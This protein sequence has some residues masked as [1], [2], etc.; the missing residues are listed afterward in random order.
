MWKKVNGVGCMIGIQKIKEVY[1]QAFKLSYSGYSYKELRKMFSEYNSQIIANAQFFAF[2]FRRTVLKTHNYP[3]K[4]NPKLFLRKQDYKFISKNQVEIIYK[5]RNRLKLKVFPTE[6]QLKLMKENRVKGAILT[7]EFFDL[8]IEK[9]ME[10]PRWEDCKSII[11]V[12]IGINNIAVAVAYTS[13]F[14]KPAFFKGGEWKHLCDRKRKITRSK[15]YKHLTNRQN[16]ILHTVSKKVVEYA[17]QF[18]KPI[19]VMER[20][21]NFNNNSWNKRFNFLLGNWARRKLQKMI[22]Y[23]ANWEGIP[24]FYV[25]PAFTSV[26]CHYCGKKGKRKGSIF[27]CSRCGRQY[28]ADLN[29]SMNL[30]LKFRQFLDEREQMIGERSGKGVSPLSEGKTYLP[31]QAQVRPGNGNQMKRMIVT[32]T[33]RFAYGIGR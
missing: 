20:L 22:E 29:A 2:K 7:D 15:E 3:K 12:D 32:R 11:G 30:V 13:K 21:G 23:K 16:E 4:L 5:P 26:I 9:E 31:V 28:N 27:K 17:K 19:I 33:L 8:I 6:K 14:H 24:V 10:L 18:E 1:T 25:N